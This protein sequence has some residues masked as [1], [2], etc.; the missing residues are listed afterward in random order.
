MLKGT[1]YEPMAEVLQLHLFLTRNRTRPF[2]PTEDYNFLLNM[3]LQVM[4]KYGI[5]NDG[6]Y[7]WIQNNQES[8]QLVLNQ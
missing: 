6:N 7:D 4:A 1:H 3:Y 2:I 5:V 8:S